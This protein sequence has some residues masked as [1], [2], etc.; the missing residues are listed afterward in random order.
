MTG[1]YLDYIRAVKYLSDLKYVV[2]LRL[3]IIQHDF[4]LNCDVIKQKCIYGICK[5]STIRE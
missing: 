3:K 4:L 1:I 5:Q 2:A